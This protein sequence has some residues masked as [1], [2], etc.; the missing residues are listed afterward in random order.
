MI[1]HHPS[2]ATLLACAAGNLPE[3]HGRVVAAHLTFCPACGRAMSQAEAVGGELLTELPPSSLAVDALART[4]A[5]LDAPLAAEPVPAPATLAALATG[6]WH[7]T[8]PGI[9]MMKLLRRDASNSRLDLIRVSP[10]VALL[11]HGH[12]GRESTCV[13]QG[14][15][16]DITGAY[17]TGDFIETDSDLAHRP[18]ALPGD[19]CI[20]LI[21]T[22]GHLQPRGILGWLVRPLLG[23]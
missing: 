12:T 16:Q 20:C 14:A 13:L 1:R 2:E 5:R 9:A 4:L 8:G 23:M 11:E 21:A 3:P 10:G 19:A 15:F 17:H 22:T 7:W 18:T 6:R